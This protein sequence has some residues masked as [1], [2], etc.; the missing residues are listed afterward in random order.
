M[1][2]SDC[3]FTG[4]GTLPEHFDFSP[5]RINDDLETTPAKSQRISAVTVSQRLEEIQ[6]VYI[7]AH[8]GQYWLYDGEGRMWRR[9]NLSGHRAIDRLISFAE[10]K[11]RATLPITSISRVSRH[12]ASQTSAS[13]IAKRFIVDGSPTARE[14][15]PIGDLNQVALME[16]TAPAG[17]EPARW[18]RNCD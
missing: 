1:R 2:S 18:E 10:I 14:I 16:R 4:D 17:D 3:S 5:A 8:L 13:L 11:S 7:T 9:T 12:P 6:V 15:R